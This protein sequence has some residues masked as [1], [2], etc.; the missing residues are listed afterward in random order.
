MTSSNTLGAAGAGLGLFSAYK[1]G[2]VGGMLSGTLSGAQLGMEVGGPIGAAIGAVGG[3]VLGLVGGGEQARVWWLKNGRTRLSNDMD[4][5]EHGGMDYLSAYMDIEQLK[6][7][8]HQTLSKMGMVGSRYYHDNVTREIGQAEAKLTREQKS[9]R[10]AGTFSTAQFAAGA[11]YVPRDGM[12]YIH[13]GERITPS[14][15]NERITRA[16]EGMSSMP[17]MAPSSSDVNLHF[18]S[19]DAKGARDL[20]MQHRGVVRS[21]LTGSYGDYGGEGDYESA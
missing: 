18:H 21:A 6:T 17:T 9:G 1:Q 20:L 16:M 2:G 7:E 19:M 15:Q 11:D 14:D 10:T 13:E 12:A 4:S 3:A 8:A 5:F